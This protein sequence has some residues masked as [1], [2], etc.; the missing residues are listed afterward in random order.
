MEALL[1]FFN[2]LDGSRYMA[3]QNEL[4][5]ISNQALESLMAQEP[6]T[7]EVPGGAYVRF[8][9]GLVASGSP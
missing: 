2:S 1:K 4:R 7:S 9:A 5:S 3:F 8:A 6:V